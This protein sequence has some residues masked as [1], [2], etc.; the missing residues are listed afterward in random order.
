MEFRT[1]S[2]LIETTWF[3]PDLVTFMKH[4][5]DPPRL[6]TRNQK[7][8]CWELASRIPGRDPSRWRFDPVGNPV[9]YPQRGCKGAVCHE[10]DHL[11]PYSK[12]G[13][14]SVI[15]ENGQILQT[16]VNRRKG[17]KPGLRID[18]LRGYSRRMRVGNKDMD[19][20]EEAIYGDVKRVEYYCSSQIQ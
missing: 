12:G 5:A 15:A 18:E 8:V 4:E 7:D 19:L 6:F 9:L 1:L 3:S 10:Y 17:S 13:R 2:R 14:T 20:I 11:W 16:Q